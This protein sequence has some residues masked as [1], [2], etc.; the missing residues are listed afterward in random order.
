LLGGV[1][2][3]IL[4][5]LMA[6]YILLKVNRLVYRLEATVTTTDA[7][8]KVDL[9]GEVAINDM[10]FNPFY[11]IHKQLSEQDPY[12]DDLEVSR[13]VDIYFEFMTVDWNKPKKGGR[14][15]KIRIKSK[16][17][18]AKDFGPSEDDEKLFATWTGISIVCVDKEALKEVKLRG[19]SSSMIS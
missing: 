5:V 9:H 14:Y 13:F 3:I 12:V 2:S 18:E 4:K 19:D 1:F 7:L 11:P 17:C 10:H 15:T 8:L 6:I 16:K